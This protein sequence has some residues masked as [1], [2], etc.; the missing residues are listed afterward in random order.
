M[1]P[2]NSCRRGTRQSLWQREVDCVQGGHPRP[3]RV[4]SVPASTSDQGACSITG[5]ALVAADGTAFGVRNAQ[6][7]HCSRCRY[8]S[9]HPRPVTAGDLDRACGLCGRYWGGDGFP[10]QREGV[11]RETAS[12][13]TL[14]CVCKES[15]PVDN[16]M[17]H[18]KNNG[19][20]HRKDEE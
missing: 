16:A 1:S 9:E 3:D 11:A 20:D 6:G 18:K 12:R 15:L 19:A 8:A 2:S 5:D 10:A 14:N 4:H 13:C 7:R 17:P